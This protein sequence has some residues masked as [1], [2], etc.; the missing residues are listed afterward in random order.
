MLELKQVSRLRLQVDVPE[1]YAPSLQGKDTVTFFLSAF[2]GKKFTGHINRQSMNMNMQYRTERVEID[3]INKDGSLTPGMYADVLLSSKGNNNAFVVPKS[4]VVTSTERKYIVVVQN[5]TAKLVD[6]TTGN[7][8]AD[9]IEVFGNVGP[10]DEV[11]VNPG[12]ELKDGS[13][14]G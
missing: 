4:A 5:G 6:V 13:K 14:A 3:V 1:A 10:D 8:S 12:D 9:K 2:P 7:Q 11:I